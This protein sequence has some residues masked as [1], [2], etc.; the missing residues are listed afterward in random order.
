MATDLTKKSLPWLYRAWTDGLNATNAEEGRMARAAMLELKR[1]NPAAFRSWLRAKTD[2]HPSKY[3]GG[4][5]R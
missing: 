5:S 3:F 1:R 2:Q 4:A